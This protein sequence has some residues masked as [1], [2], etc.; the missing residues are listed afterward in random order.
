MDASCWRRRNE[1]CRAA[2]FIA[3]NHETPAV[4]GRRCAND[5]NN[6]IAHDAQSP[7]AR[8]SPSLSLNINDVTRRLQ[9]SQSVK[10]IRTIRST[11]NTAACTMWT[12]RPSCHSLNVYTV[13]L[14][15]AAIPDNKYSGKHGLT[16]A[17]LDI[18]PVGMFTYFIATITLWS[19]VEPDKWMHAAKCTQVH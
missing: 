5:E 11:Y 12:F 2:G 19:A 7:E 1:R 6:T 9:W 13:G 18:Y 4:T 10:M 16:A 8:L 3:W 14:H 17:I 15:T